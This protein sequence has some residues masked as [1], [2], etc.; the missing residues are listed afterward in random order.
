[1]DIIEE[2]PFIYNPQ[3][4]NTLIKIAEHLSNGKEFKH[5]EMKR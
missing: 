5:P 2:S 4:M 1:M 3:I